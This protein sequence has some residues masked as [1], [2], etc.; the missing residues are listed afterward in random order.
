[1]GFYSV[2]NISKDR[3]SHSGAFFKKGILRNFAKFT[4][5]HL[6]QRPVNLFKKRLWHRCF[7]VNFAKLLRTPFLTEHLRWLLL[8]RQLFFSPFAFIDFSKNVRE[9]C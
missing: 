7:P 6:C 4:A 1:M 3:S 8:E 9:L 5:K 2:T